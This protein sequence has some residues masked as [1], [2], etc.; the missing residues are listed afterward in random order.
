MLKYAS[1]KSFGASIVGRDVYFRLWAPNQASVSL[2]LEG[3][4]LVPMQTTDDG[5][6]ELISPTARGTKYRFLLT[7]GG[8]C[9]TQHRDFSR[10][11]CTGPARWSIRIVTVGRMRLGREDPGKRA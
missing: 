2:V 11:T 4:D 5:W 6:H 3:H 7:V 10:R 9:R 1:P 8:K